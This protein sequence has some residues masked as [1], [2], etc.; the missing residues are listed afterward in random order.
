MTF[1]FVVVGNLH[2]HLKKL[3]QANSSF[4]NDMS[5]LE[6][7]KIL[8]RAIVIFPRLGRVEVIAVKQ[9]DRKLWVVILSVA[10]EPGFRPVLKPSKTKI[11][12]SRL[13]QLENGC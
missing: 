6:S 5:S 8:F 2:S 10:D 7:I 3:V 11:Q 1:A 4:Q 13:T 9:N 12:D